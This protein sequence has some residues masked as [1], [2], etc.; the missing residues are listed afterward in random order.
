METSSNSNNE[1]FQ[2][3]SLLLIKVNDKAIVLTMNSEADI[4]NYKCQLNTLIIDSQLKRVDSGLSVEAKIYEKDKESLT[5]KLQKEINTLNTTIS[6]V[7]QALAKSNADLMNAGKTYYDKAKI[8]S[9]DI[10]SNKSLNQ[11]SDTKNDETDIITL[12]ME[13]NV[14]K[15]KLDDFKTKKLTFN[16][17]EWSTS[18]VL[19]H[20]QKQYQI[21]TILNQ[22]IMFILIPLDTFE[23]P[24]NEIITKS[25]TAN[26][27]FKNGRYTSE[28]LG[29]GDKVFAMYGN[30]KEPYFATITEIINGDIR[31]Y[32]L[33]Y[34]DGDKSNKC[35]RHIEEVC[36]HM[37][38]ILRGKTYT[39]SE[40]NNNYEDC[41]LTD[42]SG[43]TQS[44]NLLKLKPDCL[45]KN[46]TP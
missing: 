9:L 29:V 41:V 15:E 2:L 13:Y 16:E 11:P 26:A 6:Q 19:N 25:D 34:S 32:K 22:K 45:Y 3:P 14:L 1:I 23:L 42:E 17:Y 28:N 12:M 37:K 40:I 8:E 10:S 24:T 38:I 18:F 21:T 36:L 39:L 35:I 44:V 30:E 4:K 7:E 46:Y 20:H 27:Y 31:G 43:N 5:V 33:L